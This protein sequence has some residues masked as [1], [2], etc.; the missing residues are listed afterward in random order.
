MH[1]FAEH[2]HEQ[3]SKLMHAWKCCPVDTCKR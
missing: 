1:I 3:R 2:N